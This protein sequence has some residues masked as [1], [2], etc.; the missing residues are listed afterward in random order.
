MPTLSSGVLR[1]DWRLHAGEVRGNRLDRGYYG[2]DEG[3]AEENVRGEGLSSPSSDGNGLR[4][5]AESE[6]QTWKTGLLSRWPP[7]MADRESRQSNEAPPIRAWWAVS[8]DRV[9]V[10]VSDPLGEAGV[11]GTRAVPQKRTDGETP[12]FP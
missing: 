11:K 4:G 7:Y 12:K 1:G 3:L 9:L 8:P 6:L 10:W 2:E 5:K